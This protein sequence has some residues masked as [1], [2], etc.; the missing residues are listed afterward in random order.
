MSKTRQEQLINWLTHQLK[1]PNSIKLEAIAGDASFRRYYRLTEHLISSY[2][3]LI[4]V[5]A[6]PTYEDN[7]AFCLIAKLL[8]QQGLMAPQVIHVEFKQGFLLLTDLGSK[9]YLDAL[10]DKNVNQL[11]CQAI[12]SII[13]M[14]AIPSDQLSQLPDYDEKALNDEMALFNEWFIK[15][16]LKLDLSLEEQALIDTTFI[17]L[18]QNALQQPQVFVHRDYHSRNLMIC[19]KK[20]PGII[21]FQDAVIG[22]LSYDLVSLLKDC[23]IEWPHQSVVD[24][25]EYFYNQLVLSEPDYMVDFNTFFK[26]FELMGMQRHI[27]VLGIFC[28]LFYRDAKESYLDDLALTFKY[29]ITTAQRYPEFEEFYVFL[30]KKIKPHLK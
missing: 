2:Q 10:N 8:E 4:A 1:L 12:D 22:A 7:Q 23:Y 9:L 30:N 11:Y 27:K 14:Q 21:D 19:N 26:Q 3:T 24:W 28:R 6:P 17:Q 16:H 20:S 13:Q 25:C 29:L 18:T 15:H 5:D